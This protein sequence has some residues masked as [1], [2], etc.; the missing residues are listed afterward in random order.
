MDNTTQLKCFGDGWFDDR[1]L[2]NVLSVS[3]VRKQVGPENIGYDAEKDAF[4]VVVGNRHFEFI[5]SKEGLYYYLPKNAPQDL[6]PTCFLELQDETQKLCTPR[7]YKQAIKARKL[8]HAAGHPN[9]AD[10]VK[11]VQSIKLS[12]AL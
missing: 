4:W 10:L 12:I 2:T 7:E 8:V 1:A 6:E 3:L 5:G 11:I 9:P